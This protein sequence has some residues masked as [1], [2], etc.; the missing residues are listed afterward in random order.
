MPLPH[1]QD[2]ESEA[3]QADT[4]I[5]VAA[6]DLG[7]PDEEIAR[8]QR[9]RT[10]LALGLAAAL[11][12]AVLSA[13]SQRR[14]TEEDRRVRRAAE[15]ASISATVLL[16]TA[17]GARSEVGDELGVAGDRVTLTRESSVT[18]VT[19]RTTYIVATRITSF[20]VDDGTLTPTAAC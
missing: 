8:R 6:T 3:W 20:V 17:F 10:M 11:G 13:H 16:D 9:L 5:V 18:C 12:L 19:V 7:T 15:T 14:A 1:R 2:Q 4:L